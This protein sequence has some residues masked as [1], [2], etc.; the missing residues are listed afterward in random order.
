[1]LFF[2]KY[3]LKQTSEK[4]TT[5]QNIILTAFFDT[6]VFLI[7]VMLCVVYMPCV[8]ERVCISFWADILLR[9]SERGRRR[10]RTREKIHKKP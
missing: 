2:F 8:K 3:L 1:M 9:R 5:K 10:T 6:C 4:H 7:N